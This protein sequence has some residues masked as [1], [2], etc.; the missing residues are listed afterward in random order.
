M[1]YYNTW[2]NLTMNNVLKTIGLNSV[3][4]LS[5]LIPVFKS[6]PP[7]PVCMPKY[8]ALFA[9]FGLELGD[10]S[11]YLIPV[12]LIGMAVSVISI[13]YKCNKKGLKLYPFYL[14]LSSCLFIIVCKFM[15][16]NTIG[17]YIGMFGLFIGVIQHH[18][19]LKKN[20]ACCKH[21]GTRSTDPRL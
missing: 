7:C 19:L 13:Y 17:V 3:T 16:D 5:S 11:G 14:V 2:N 15:L 18:F 8:A 9:F 1:L 6:C 10:Y 20:S 21:G 12:M 4:F